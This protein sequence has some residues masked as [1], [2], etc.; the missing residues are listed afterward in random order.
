MD[1]N[2]YLPLSNSSV[3][4]AGVPIS[5]INHQAVGAAPDIGAL[6]LGIMPWQ[7]G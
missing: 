2:T 4:D 5:A 6:E 1:T 7:A 3:V